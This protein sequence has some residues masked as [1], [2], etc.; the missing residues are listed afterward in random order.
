MLV[1][2]MLG[3]FIGSTFGLLVSAV[4]YASSDDEHWD[5]C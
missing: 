1:G 5:G 4:L 2:F 3:L